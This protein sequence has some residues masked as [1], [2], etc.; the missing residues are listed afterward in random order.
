MTALAYTPTTQAQVGKG[1][2]SERRELFSPTQNDCTD[3]GIIR[4]V[5]DAGIVLPLFYDL[6]REREA[7]E[8]SN[9]RPDETGETIGSIVEAAT[10]RY[11]FAGHSV[12]DLRAS[13]TT[14]GTIVLVQGWNYRLP[15]R[16]RAYPNF[17][18]G[19]AGDVRVNRDA[20]LTWLDPGRPHGYRGDPI[21]LAE[22]LHF[23]WGARYARQATWGE[24]LHL[25]YGGRRLKN[26]RSFE[27]W[28]AKPVNVWTRPTLRSAHAKTSSGDD[29]VLHRGDRF[30]PRQ[31]TA[32]GQRVAGDSRW[33]GNAAGD[34]WVRIGP[35]RTVKS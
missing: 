32:F 4:M 10:N 19:H 16:L 13:L 22:A 1:V 9:S 35:M 29:A 15:K 7:L 17:G 6:D 26:P 18:G 27:V 24:V 12:T 11:H 23:A 28:T 5:M 20:S 8:R 31:I 2:V 33:L 3:A 34:R 30:T 25:R 14:P 21:T